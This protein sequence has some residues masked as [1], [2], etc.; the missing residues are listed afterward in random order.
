MLTSAAG[1][2]GETLPSI[3]F[4]QSRAPK[5]QPARNRSGKRTAGNRLTLESDQLMFSGT[6]STE[7]AQALRLPDRGA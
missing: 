7:G 6:G 4:T 3:M 1:P 2:A 5:A